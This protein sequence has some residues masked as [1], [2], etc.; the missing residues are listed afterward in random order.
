MVQ[1][2]VPPT[3]PEG[4]ARRFG[5]LLSTNDSTWGG[6]AAQ[7]TELAVGLRATG[8]NPV[9]LT[10]PLGGG[11]LVRRARALGLTT[12]LLPLRVMRRR[13]PF[14]DYYSVWRLS[15]R[16]ILKRERIAIVHTHDPR[17]GLAVMP[18]AAGLRLP[19]VWHIHDLD[20]DWVKPRTLR[21][22]N[23]P[24]SV[25]VAIS[26]AAARWAIARGVDPAH[27]RRIYNGIHLAPFSATARAEA[28]RSLGIADDEIA[29]ALVGR[30]HPRK[31]Q[32]DL[33]WAAAHPD[34][35]DL[36]IRFFFLGAAEREGGAADYERELRDLAATKGVEHRVVFLGLREDAPALLAGFDISAV[37]SRREAFGRVV[38]ESMHAGTP[39]AV[40]DDGALPE[41]V[42]HEREGLVVPVGNP[43]AL[44]A[45]IGRLARDPALRARLGAN[46]RVR[47]R[48][49]SHERWL[50]HMTALYRELLGIAPTSESAAHQLSGSLPT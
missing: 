14:V 4:E 24:G 29:V 6:L 27:L 28:R 49:F 5:V 16:S 26:D 50:G 9:I 35:H 30:L 8:F 25:V 38:V 3:S 32:E 39:I 40:Y 43:R 31:G 18:A 11:E 13:F 21:L 41:L 1:P 42:R 12:Y 34:L 7:M 17:S 10:T 36:N 44:A 48:D 46:A 23:R 2:D 37:P 19:L 20:L 33:I 47:A 22:Q 45:A 15:L